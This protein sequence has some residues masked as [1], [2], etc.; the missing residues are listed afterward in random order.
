MIPRTILDCIGAEDLLGK[1][2]MLFSNA[3]A[4][5]KPQRIQGIF[6]ST[7]EVNR[8]TNRLK[9]IGQP[10][11]DES[12]LEGDEEREAIQDLTTLA[13]KEETSIKKQ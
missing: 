1:G 10:E 8:V 7:D 4:L 9:I 3:K 5:T 12:I 11:Y 6:I 2:D 13:V